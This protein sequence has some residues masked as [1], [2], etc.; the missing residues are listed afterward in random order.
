MSDKINSKLFDNLC[1]DVKEY[2][3]GD[4]G[5]L[6]VKHP[7]L[8]YVSPYRFYKETKNVSKIRYVFEQEI[9]QFEPQ[10]SQSS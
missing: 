2:Y 8:N 6:Y 1:N 4:L 3:N 9:K 10:V 7:Q 5:W